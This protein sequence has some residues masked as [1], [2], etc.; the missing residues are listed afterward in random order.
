MIE[1]VK[2]LSHKIQTVLL[3]YGTLH[4]GDN[5][6]KSFEYHLLIHDAEYVFSGVSMYSRAASCIGLPALR[7]RGNIIWVT[8]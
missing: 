7:L 3:L 1:D 2:C 5:L 4:R 8:R 6:L